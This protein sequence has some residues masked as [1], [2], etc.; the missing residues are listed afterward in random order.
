[1]NPDE[2]A[3]EN[4]FLK[5]K[6]MAE[7]GGNFVGGD[8]IPAELE[9]QFLKQIIQYH[10]LHSDSETVSIY[11]FI[12]EPEYNHV[13]DLSDKQVK[14]QLRTLLKLLQKHGIKLDVLS[15]IPEREVYRFI[16]EELFKQPISNVKMKGW[17]SQ[18]VYEDFHP[19][20]EYD[21]KNAV[22][23]ILIALFDRQGSLYE[24]FVAEEL[25]DSL[26]LSSDP[27]ELLRKIQAF[28]EQYNDIIL[29]N[30][31]YLE[32]DINSNEGTARLLL[33]VTFKT[34]KQ[35]GKRTARHVTHVE[36]FLRRDGLMKNI[37]QL[38]RLN[39]E[40]F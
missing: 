36:L 19:N 1:M 9:N 15:Q 24:D 12:G 26:G 6:M 29:V 14:K 11:H 8:K 3:S 35:K 34:Q 13:H 22:H 30:Y 28:H 10:K 25:K 39:S 17:V 31:D 4:E 38:T 37:W 23:H 20:A 21:V 16:T 27:E 18:F 2:L 32:T 33:D 7:F 40:F 5:L